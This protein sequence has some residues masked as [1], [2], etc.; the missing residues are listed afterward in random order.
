MTTLDKVEARLHEIE[1]AII[2]RFAE[3]ASMTVDQMKAAIK[4]DEAIKAYYHEVREK[5]ILGLYE[6]EVDARG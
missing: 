2:E 6:A 3:T 4:S 5:V 1:T